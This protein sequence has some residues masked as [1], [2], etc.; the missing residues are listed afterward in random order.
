MDDILIHAES[1]EKL[2]TIT[3]PDKAGLKLNKKK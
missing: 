1:L 3:N 2:Y